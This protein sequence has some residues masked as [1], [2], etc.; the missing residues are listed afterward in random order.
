M[1]E[2]P[3]TSVAPTDRSSGVFDYISA[4]RLNLWIRCP[5]AFRLRYYDGIRTPPSPAL[6][7]GQRVHHGLEVWYRHQQLGIPINRDAVFEQM[8]SSW[9]Q[10]VA[11]E[12]I[13]F[14]GT[15]EE[16]ALK[17]Q[18][19]DLVQH[20]VPPDPERIRRSKDSGK[21]AL[22]VLEPGKRVRLDFT[23]YHQ[24]GDTLSV[25]M[26]LTDNRLLGLSVKTYL[27]SPEDAVVLDVRFS[28]LADGSSYA[29]DVTLEAAAKNL[30]VAMQNTGY[31][32]IR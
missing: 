32:K 16:Q 22:H 21:A 26:G 9:G 18:A 23:D 4:S 25:E 7:L 31:K 6:F 19:V 20:Y 14:A 2:L 3:T 28:I 8:R 17:Q 30:A 10:A 29:S 24:P 15:S 5:L 13:E 11:E 1:I 27:K 12:G